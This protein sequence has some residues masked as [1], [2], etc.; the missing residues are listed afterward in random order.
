MTLGVVAEE[1]ITH[2]IS[3]AN[4]AVNAGQTSAALDV[5]EGGFKYSGGHDERPSLDFFKHPSFLL[6][7]KLSLIWY[8]LKRCHGSK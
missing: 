8:A 4:K 6:S 1:N 7:V 2:A 5:T 3:K